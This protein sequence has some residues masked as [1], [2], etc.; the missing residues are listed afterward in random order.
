LPFQHGM[1]SRREAIHYHHVVVRQASDTDRL[2]SKR[3]L[4]SLLVSTLYNKP[5]YF[6]LHHL[7][8]PLVA[9]T[10]P[11]KLHIILAGV[12]ESIRSGLIGFPHSK[13]GKSR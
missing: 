3:D 6:L 13:G 5:G 12:R 1:S 8:S 4:S 7:T 10:L 11:D 9:L 2:V